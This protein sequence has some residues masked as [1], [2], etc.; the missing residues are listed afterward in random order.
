MNII[1]RCFSLMLCLV[2][3]MAAADEFVAKHSGIKIVQNGVAIAMMSDDEAGTTV[4]QLVPEAFEIHSPDAMTQVCTWSSAT[5]FT[6]VKAGS[7]IMQ[8]FNSCMFL[9]KSMA[10]NKEAD[11]LILSQDNGYSL[12]ESHGSR[13]ISEQE[14]VYTVTQLLEHGKQ[15]SKKA[16]GVAVFMVV[17]IDANK[18]KVVDEDEFDR[19]ELR[20]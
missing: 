19:L 6:K 9:Y 16:L 8:D 1:K 10:M 15:M 17:W 12:N 14:F 4:V 13:K 3:Y 5:I 11:Y 20:F 2:S 7:D 18:N